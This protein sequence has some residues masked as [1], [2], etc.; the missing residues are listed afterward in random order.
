MTS[1]VAAD[2]IALLP[3]ADP[4][5]TELGKVM[6]EQFAREQ[7]VKR[8]FEVIGADSLGN[9]LRNLRVRNTA[10]PIES[11]VHA[12]GDSLNAQFIL[13]GTIHSFTLDSTFS[14][15]SVC[16]R[17][18]RAGDSKIVWDNCVSLS[19]SGEE[20]LISKPVHDSYRKM[21]KSATKKLFATLRLKARPQRTF[22]SDL[23][24]AGREKKELIACSPIAVIPPVDESE[25][26]FAGEM[27][28]NFLVTS[29]VRRG[30]NVIDPGRVRNVMLQCEDL[31]HGQS[32]NTVSKM[33]ADSLGVTLVVTGT[34]S[35]LT[36]AR[37]AMLGSSPEAAI[38]LRMIDPRRNI[39]VWASHVERS[40]DSRKGLF[41]TGVVHS[42]AV[43]ALD[44]IEDAVD[45]L[46]VVRRKFD[47]P[48]N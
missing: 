7:L 10:T 29:L 17:L 43:L 22:V 13:T 25:V 12:I 15:V 31:R 28:G 8:G 16:A 2:R 30:F 6:F 19:G 33:L 27:V 44:M 34:I 32:V 14:E 9:V 23:M 47:Q 46:R 20:A 35:K 21:A 36:E 42:P 45:G 39:V 41:E 37:S 5:S 48:L 3:F 40:G 4:N 26:A 18:L 24:V 1:V 38:E 11:E